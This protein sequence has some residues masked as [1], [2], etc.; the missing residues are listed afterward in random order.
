MKAPLKML[1]LVVASMAVAGLGLALRVVAAPLD[2]QVL[3]A[4]AP[5][6]NGTVTLWQAGSGA[7]RQVAQTRSGVDGRFV[8]AAPDAPLSEGSQ[9]DEA[10]E[11]GWIVISMKDDWKKIFAFD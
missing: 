11:Q 4:G 10:K 7:P 2:G 8:L 3:G 1:R 9:Y 6:D 5:V